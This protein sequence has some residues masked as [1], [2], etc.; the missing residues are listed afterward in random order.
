MHPTYSFPHSF[1]PLNATLRCNSHSADLEATVFSEV[2][3]FAIDKGLW[4]KKSGNATDEEFSASGKSNFPIGAS[5]I[6]R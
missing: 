6:V 4:G 5:S 2:N 1:F 3:F